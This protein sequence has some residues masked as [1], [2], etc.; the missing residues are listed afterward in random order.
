MPVAAASFCFLSLSFTPLIF[1]LFLPLARLSA[2]PPFRRHDSPFHTPLP[3]LIDC[4]Y[5][6]HAAIIDTLMRCLQR[7]YAAR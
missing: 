3:L 2:P 1:S 4:H 5:C 6:R 7:H